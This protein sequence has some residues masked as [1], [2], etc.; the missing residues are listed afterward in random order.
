MLN[1]E[2]KQ[3]LA[4]FDKELPCLLILFAMHYEH[5]FEKEVTIN[6]YTID[7]FFYTCQIIEPFYEI[8]S[9]SQAQIDEFFDKMYAKYSEEN[10]KIK[11]FPVSLSVND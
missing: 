3:V 8:I 6:Q 11:I 1:E 2:T 10:D 7:R 5:N 9:N 4:T